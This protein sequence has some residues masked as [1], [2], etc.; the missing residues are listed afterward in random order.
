MGCWF[1]GCRC[2]SEG[3]CSSLIP[4]LRSEVHHLTVAAGL[5]TSVLPHRQ[6]LHRAH[7][8]YYY[9]LRQPNLLSRSIYH[10]LLLDVVCRAVSCRSMPRVLGL[11]ALSEAAL[12]ACIRSISKF[13][14]ISDSRQ[15]GVWEAANLTSRWLGTLP[16]LLHAAS[17]VHGCCHRSWQ[18]ATL[19]TCLH[20]ITVFARASPASRKQLNL[21]NIDLKQLAS[22]SP[23]RWRR[24]CP[25]YT[26]Q[27][28]LRGSVPNRDKSEVR[29]WFALLLSAC[30]Q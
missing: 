23:P 28:S 3:C 16:R 4:R 2:Q 13:L 14:W 17:V 10:Q 7:G 11:L 15:R 25:S 22:W 6:G 24:S 21:C 30:M 8:P 9:H 19:G 27:S 5:Q 1:G 26:L 18:Q 29:T 12:P 20:S